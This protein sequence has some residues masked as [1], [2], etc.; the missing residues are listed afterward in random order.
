MGA[1]DNEANNK[2]TPTP[3]EQTYLV[4]QGKCPHNQGWTHDG[5]GH[6]DDCYKCKLCG[7]TEWY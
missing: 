2:F 4:L 3:E 5:H 1:W 7:Q 6:N